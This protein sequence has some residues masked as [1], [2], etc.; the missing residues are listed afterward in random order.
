MAAG[1][2]IFHQINLIQNTTLSSTSVI[3]S[4]P[5][6]I[7]NTD[8][9]AVQF[10]WSGTPSGSFFVDASVDFIRDPYGNVTNL[11]NWNILSSTSVGQA[12]SSSGLLLYTINQSPYPYIRT[13]Y[14]P[15]SASSSGVLNVWVGAKQL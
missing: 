5:L 2:N 9:I 10:N 13:R 4:T 11:G 15:S 14:V 8:N 3:Y 7:Q 1:K 12:L 6:Y